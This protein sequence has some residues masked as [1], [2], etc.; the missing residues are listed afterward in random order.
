MR[1]ITFPIVGF[2]IVNILETKL[3]TCRLIN[4]GSEITIFKSFILKNWEKT[5]I[6]IKRVTG[7]KERITKQKEIVEIMIQ[8]KI[9]KIG[10]VY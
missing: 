3:Y 10:K 7:N 9:I 4:T 5:K 2:I 6:S 1:E 8:N